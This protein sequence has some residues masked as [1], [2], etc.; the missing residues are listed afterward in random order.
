M[1]NNFHYSP[2]Y[3]VGGDINPRRFVMQDVSADHTILQAT[4]GART[5]GISQTGVIDPPGT[6]GASGLAGRASSGNKTMTV[7]GPGSADIQL[8]AGTGG[9]VRGDFLKPDANGKGIPALPG[10]AAGALALCSAAAGEYGRVLIIDP[11]VVPFSGPGVVLVTTTPYTV[12]VAQSGATFISLVVDCVFNLPATQL[13]LE[14]HFINGILSTTTGMSISPVAADQIIA[15]GITPADDKDFINTAAT[16]AIGD[17][18]S[19]YGDGSLGYY[20]VVEAGTFAR[21]A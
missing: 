2:N 14:Y 4:A 21:E 6:T 7:H 10:E 15:K 18:A 8:E 19:V 20:G 11:L 13:G 1:S 16:D 9:Y 17:A 5:V 3:I 12:T